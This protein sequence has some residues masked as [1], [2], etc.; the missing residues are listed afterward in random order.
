MIGCC[1]A[2]EGQGAQSV[3]ATVHPLNGHGIASWE[4]ARV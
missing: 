4:Q 2:N 1:Q 3:A